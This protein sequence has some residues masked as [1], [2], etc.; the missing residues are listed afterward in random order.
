[1]STATLT[2]SEHRIVLSEDPSLTPRANALLTEQLRD[3]IGSDEV[4]V[5][6]GTTHH[7]AER[8]ATH[9]WFVGTL[10]EI[11]IGVAVMAFS[12]LVTGAILTLVTGSV[13]ALV[14][15]LVLHGIGT[16]AV[17]SATLRT[18]GENEHL[19][20]ELGARLEAEGVADPDRV[21][22]DLLE[23]FTG[24]KPAPWRGV[25]PDRPR[26]GPAAP[27]GSPSPV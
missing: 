27:L 5:P 25:Q 26:R 14:G 8:H 12:L 10:I 6:T 2:T 16:F 11:Q 3:V 1:M 15:A 19:S 22:E 23:E 9:P 13:W 24:V 17:F 7:A 18:M 20:P 21:F 4:D